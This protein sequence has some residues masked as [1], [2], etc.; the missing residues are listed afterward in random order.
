MKDNKD[1]DNIISSNKDLTNILNMFVKVNEEFNI[2][3]SK[4]SSKKIEDGLE[5]IINISTIEILQENQNSLKLDFTKIIDKLP[6]TLSS[7]IKL[8]YLN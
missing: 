8:K 2:N 1:L 7:Y 6:F 3:I 5:K 4:Y